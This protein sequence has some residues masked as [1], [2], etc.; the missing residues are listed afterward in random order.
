[1]GPD[2]FVS[3]S[4]KG[5]GGIEHRLVLTAW[6]GRD[7]L[8]SAKALVADVVKAVLAMPRHEAGLKIVTLRFVRGLVKR[9]PRRWTEGRM[10]F[11]AR[12]VREDD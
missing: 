12:T 9:D 3:W 6:V 4:W 1:M 5:G 10:E 11:L 8:A 2:S 7:G